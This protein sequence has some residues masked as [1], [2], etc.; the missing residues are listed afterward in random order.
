MALIAPTRLPR[1]Q[2]LAPSPHQPPIYPPLQRVP[3]PPGRGTPAPRFL[4]RNLRRPRVHA[5]AGPARPHPPAR[6]SLPLPTD[7]RWHFLGCRHGLGLLLDRTRFEVTVWDPVAGD[8]RRVAIPP[9]LFSTDG[10]KAVW[11]GALLCDDGHSVCCSSKPFKV[12]LLRTDDWVGH[13]PQ[14][15]ASLYESKTGVWSNLASTSVKAPLALIQLQPG[16]LVGNSFFWLLLGYEKGGILEF[17]LDRQS[18]A[19]IKYPAA[20]HVTRY[21]DFQIVRME[22]GRLGLAISS[23]G[24]IQLWERKASSVG[25]T[26]WMLQ[27]TIELDKLLSLQVPMDSSDAVMLGYDEDGHVIFISTSVELFMIQLKS[28]QFRK[29]FMRHTI[30]TYHPYRSFFTIGNRSSLL[31]RNN[32]FAIT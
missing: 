32:I 5:Y 11:N 20:A 14:A 29:L 25:I 2:A 7:E 18:L 19:T 13:D 24:S 16:I 22:D 10:P 4:R 3:L 21:S 9:E 26:E 6:L 28:M 8:K 31:F 12:V 23:D 27:K 30:T 17:D 1:L 15:F